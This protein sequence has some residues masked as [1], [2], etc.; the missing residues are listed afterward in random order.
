MSSPGGDQPR[1]FSF[2]SVGKMA[3]SFCNRPESH[4]DDSDLRHGHLL[5]PSVMIRQSS[6]SIS[7]SPSFTKE[8]VST[9]TADT[10]PEDSA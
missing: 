10:V 9:F 5:H 8:P 7:T 6:N 2:T 3:D 1:R 4:L